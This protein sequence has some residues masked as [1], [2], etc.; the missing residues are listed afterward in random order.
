MAGAMCSSIICNGGCWDNAPSESRWGVL[1]VARQ[2]GVR[3]VIGWA[4]MD[5][6][7]DWMTFYNHRRLHST[8]SYVSPIQFAQRWHAAQEK[9]AA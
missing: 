9:R 5:E 8:L 7:L 1:K 3:F 4:A 6:V 2:H